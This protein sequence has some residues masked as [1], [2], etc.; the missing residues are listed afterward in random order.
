MLTINDGILTYSSL[1]G[2]IRSIALSEVEKAEIKI[3]CFTYSDRLKPTVRLEINSKSTIHKN[4]V[5]NVKVFKKEQIK[6]EF[7]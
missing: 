1:F 7:S 6:K 4:I 2:G 3:G 5:I